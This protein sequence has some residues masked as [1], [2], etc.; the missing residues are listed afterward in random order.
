MIHAK[1]RSTAKVV[2]RLSPK[3]AAMGRGVPNPVA[4]FDIDETLLINLSATNEDA[5]RPNPPIVALAQDLLKSGKWKVH[6]VTARPASK[7]NMDWSV[8]QL[9]QIGIPTAKLAGFHMMPPRSHSASRFKENARKRIATTGTILL[10]VGDQ[11][12][13]LMR[14]GQSAAGEKPTYLIENPAPTTAWSIKLPQ[15]Y[16][17]R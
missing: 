4:V 5:I 12:G 13:D 6:V 17:V 2:G 10:S 15:R 14:R 8:K 16:G 3:L 1:D 11:W 7:A 9:E